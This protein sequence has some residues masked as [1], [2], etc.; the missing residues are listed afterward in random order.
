MSDQN[1]SATLPHESVD[2]GTVPSVDKGKGKA[3]EA[4]AHDVSMDEDDSS[5][6]EEAPE[7]SS[8]KLILLLNLSTMRS[9]LTSSLRLRVPVRINFP[10]HIV[11]WTSID[12]T[13]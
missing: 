10:L 4:V 2:S 6:E 12:M 11:L 13:I 7:V 1:G 5:S 3:T 8:I 9:N